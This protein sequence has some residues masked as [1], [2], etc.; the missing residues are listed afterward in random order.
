M[1]RRPN[2]VSSE[3]SYLF[4]LRKEKINPGGDDDAEQMLVDIDIPKHI[5]PRPWDQPPRLSQ[6]G[7]CK[8]ARYCSQACQQ[9]DWVTHKVVCVED[10]ITFVLAVQD[11]VSVMDGVV[12][13]CG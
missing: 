12:A 13:P 6:C 5:T 4:Q 10:D 3:R 1:S 7:K 9:Q 2:K 8:L 11:A